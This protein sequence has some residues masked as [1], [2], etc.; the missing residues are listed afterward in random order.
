M[1]ERL[2]EDAC[3]VVT[4]DYPA[5]FL[6]RMLAAAG[7][8]LSA[9]KGAR[10][11]AIDSNGL[12]PMRAAPKAFGRAYDFRR[13]LQRELEPHLNQMPC[14][15]PLFTELEQLEDL[16]ADV[17]ERWPAARSGCPWC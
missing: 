5:F 17:L 4:D 1:L 7:R 2:A 13:F 16:P 12:L 6:P 14:R 3:A 8:R 10:L 15:E 11:E 9:S